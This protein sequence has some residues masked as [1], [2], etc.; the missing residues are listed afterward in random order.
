[1]TKKPRDEPQGDKTPSPPGKQKPFELR[2][3]PKPERKLVGKGNLSGP[4][5]GQ[6]F[7]HQGR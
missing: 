5:K 1:M 3:P 4:K 6:S 2:T 7:R